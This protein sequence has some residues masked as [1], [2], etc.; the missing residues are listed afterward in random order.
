MEKGQGYP[1]TKNTEKKS[2]KIPSNQTRYYHIYIINKSNKF[3]TSN[4]NKAASLTALDLSVA[5][6]SGYI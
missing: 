2:C 4:N 6:A 1:I 3:L 5:E